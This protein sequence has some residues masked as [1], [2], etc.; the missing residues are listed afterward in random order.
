[1][2]EIILQETKDSFTSLELVDLINK[3]REEEGNKNP[4]RHD[5]LLQI[6]RDE[7]EHEISLRKILESKYTNERGRKYPMFILNLEQSRQILV[8]ESR[9]VRRAVTE[10]IDKLDE[11]LKEV[12]VPQTYIEALYLY[13]IY[14]T[15]IEREVA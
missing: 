6:I 8:R 14:K 12:L 4:L 13:Q 9:F 15:Q 11:K 2:N 5:N 1:M 7:F 10:Y 3:F